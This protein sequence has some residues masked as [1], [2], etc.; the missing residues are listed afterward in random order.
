VT[1]SGNEL[2]FDYK[3]KQGVCQ[4]LNAT[5]LMKKIGIDL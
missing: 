3:L 2:S 1:I 5:L 4:T